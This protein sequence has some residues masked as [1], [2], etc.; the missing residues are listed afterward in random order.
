[1]SGQELAW[2]CYDFAVEQFGLTARTVLD[3]WG[4]HATEDI[5]RIVFILIEIGLFMKDGSDRVED[6]DAV[7]DFAE[8][9]DRS[10][11]WAGVSQAQR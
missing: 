11:P 5:G 7:Y 4:L 10:Y 2:A 6:F 3:H 8:A 1:M 9:F